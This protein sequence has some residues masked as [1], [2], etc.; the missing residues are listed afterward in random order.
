MSTCQRRSC[1]VSQLPPGDRPLQEWARGT[2]TNGYEGT[3][4]SHSRPSGGHL[5]THEAQ[6]RGGMAT[7]TGGAQGFPNSPVWQHRAGWSLGSQ[8]PPV[9]SAS[10]GSQSRERRSMSKERKTQAG[11]SPLHSGSVSNRAAQDGGLGHGCSHWRCRRW[12]QPW[13]GGKGHMLRGT[14]ACPGRGAPPP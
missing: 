9:L 13:G 6:Q 1:P 14:P 12:S 11:R 10:S 8:P 4:R 5:L 2:G 3:G 7:G